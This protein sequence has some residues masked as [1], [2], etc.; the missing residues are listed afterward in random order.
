[1]R[2]L[3]FTLLLIFLN[4]FYLMSQNIDI[5]EFVKN[6]LSIKNNFIQIKKIEDLIDKK[7]Y[8]KKFLKVNKQFPKDLTFRPN[9]I[10]KIA[11]D[12][13]LNK[14]T[15]LYLTNDLSAMLLFEKSSLPFEMQEKYEKIICKKNKNLFESIGQVLTLNC[16]VREINDF[17]YFIS[18]VKLIEH[19]GLDLELYNWSNQ[20]WIEIDG[21]NCHIVIHSDIGLKFEDVLNTTVSGYTYSQVTK[22]G[23]FSKA[24]ELNLNDSHAYY[25]KGISKYD[26]NNL[27]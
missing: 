2:K 14:N 15:L 17:K 21:F 7:G 1:M 9:Q 4:S 16:G 12:L 18:E 25:N 11:K 24:I 3:L 5:N 23:D 27:Q 8:L 19:K 20:Y 26:L 13:F 22:S 10:K 6:N